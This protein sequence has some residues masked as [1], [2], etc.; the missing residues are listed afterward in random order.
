MGTRQVVDL[1][2]LR[3]PALLSL[4]GRFGDVGLGDPFAMPFQTIEAVLPLRG[5]RLA[6]VN[7]H[8]LLLNRPQPCAIGRQR[9]HPGP[10]A[11]T[12]A[13]VALPAVCS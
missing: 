9:V 1:L 11:G 10:G 5:D 12:T 6:I 2:E 7:E 4:P 8:E 3:D 13:S